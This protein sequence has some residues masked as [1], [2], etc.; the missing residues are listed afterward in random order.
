M[1]FL[2]LASAAFFLVI[3]SQVCS[4]QT[5]PK[6]KSVPVTLNLQAVKASPAYAE[7]LFRRTEVLSELE[8]L[9][10]EYTEE[11]PKVKALRF[12]GDL[13]NKELEK[14]LA[15][16]PAEASKLTLALGKLIARRIEIETDIWSLG[17]QF[18]DQHPDIKRARRRAEIFDAAIKEIMQGK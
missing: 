13:L 3:F 14:L 12:E 2:K 17:K 10:V 9:L 8:S 16:S 15:V 7:V 5:G 11:F 6:N 18:N 1:K 4:A